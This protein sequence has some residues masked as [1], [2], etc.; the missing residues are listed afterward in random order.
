MFLNIAKD[1]EIT[2]KFQFTGT[3]MQPQRNR[4]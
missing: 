4:K 3:G 1:G 2:K